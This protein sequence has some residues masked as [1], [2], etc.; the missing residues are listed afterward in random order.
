METTLFPARL[1]ELGAPLEAALRAL[2]PERLAAAAGPVLHWQAGW[3]LVLLG[4]LSGALLGL[5]FHREGFAGGYASLRRRL[6]RLGHVAL[7]ALG[8]LNLIVSCAPPERLAPA[9]SLLLLAGSVLMPATCFLA[10]W[11]TPLRHAFALP[12]LA[13]AGAVVCFLAHS[14]HGGPR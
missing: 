12:V 4:S 7:V 8:S 13:L 11:R 3:V 6:L 2:A 1:A 5:G 9:A 10:G 14:L